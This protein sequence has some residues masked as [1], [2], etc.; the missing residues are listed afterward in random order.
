MSQHD[1]Q[2]WLEVNR[3]RHDPLTYAAILEGK[4]TKWLAQWKDSTDK[5]ALQET[6]DVLKETGPL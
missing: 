5:G 4:K 2:I 6:I 3:L 1:R